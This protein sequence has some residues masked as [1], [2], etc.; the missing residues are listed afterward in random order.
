MASSGWRVDVRT[1]HGHL[2]GRAH[3]YSTL[4]TDAARAARGQNRALAAQLAD[5][6][7]QLECSKDAQVVLEAVRELAA[8]MPQDPL[9]SDAPPSLQRYVRL[10]QRSQIIDHQALV[11]DWLVHSEAWLSTDAREEIKPAIVA[12][13]RAASEARAELLGDAFYGVSVVYGLVHRMDESAVEIESNEEPMLVPRE[14]L[15][16]QGL[17]HIGQAVALLCEVLP[18]GGSLVL[19]MAAVDLDLEPADRVASP[20]ELE[21][22]DDYE[23]AGGTQA[24]ILSPRDAAWIK[25]GRN[26]PFAAASAASLRRR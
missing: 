21:D 10:R 9:S 13:A 20:W 12:L 24:A 3:L 5:R 25:R 17:A 7:K 14:E 23:A 16:R 4:N 6:A 19:P 1:A 2:L 8:A 11:R 22:D 15:E 18:A 26:R